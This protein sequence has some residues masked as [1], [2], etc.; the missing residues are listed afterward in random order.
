MADTLLN[1][2]P[3]QEYT[4]NQNPINILYN[5]LKEHDI[6]YH[7]H[8]IEPSCYYLFSILKH[9]LPLNHY[10]EKMEIYFE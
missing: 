10:V 3:H 7:S 4:Q 8:Y 5:Q 1:S 6:Y 9:Y 2:E